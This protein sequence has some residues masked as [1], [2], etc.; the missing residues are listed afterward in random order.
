MVLE[1]MLIAVE[2]FV[3]AYG[4]SGAFVIAVLESFIFPIPTA[5]IIAPATTFGVDP[6]FITIVATI[7]SVLGAVVGY[8]LG[9]YLG[10]PVAERLFKKKLQG[11]EKWFDKYGAWAVLIAA[12]TPI[13]FKVFTWASGIF[14]LDMK[15][16]LVASLIGRFVQFAIAAYVGSLFGP[17][18]LSWFGI[19]L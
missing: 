5:V 18:L 8:G 16:F 10:R 9:K 19:A 17:I 2:E 11:V 1:G 12:F 15:K 13:P 4:L 6:F 14:E 7:G 3:T